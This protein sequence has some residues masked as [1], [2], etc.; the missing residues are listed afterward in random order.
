MLLS[1][2]AAR[3]LVAGAIGIAAVAGAAA[4]GAVPSAIADP[5]PPPAPG[6]SAADFEQVTGEVSTATSGYFFTHPDVNAFF[7]SVRGQPRD[8]AKQEINGYLDAN[9]QTKSD[10]AGIRQPLHDMKARCQ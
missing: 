7:S 10:L 3:R 8:Q 2:S 6:C 1:T 4:L 5:P 9:P